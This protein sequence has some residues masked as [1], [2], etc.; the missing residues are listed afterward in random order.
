[1][2]GQPQARP[3]PLAGLDWL[4]ECDLT[5]N[6]FPC[7]RPATHT[8]HIHQCKKEEKHL[9]QDTFLVCAYTVKNCLEDIYPFR[10]RACNHAFGSF[11]D[12][13]WDIAELPKG[14]FH[15]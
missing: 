9:E 7:H 12:R 11:L 15:E 5:H 8:A 6:G 10:C 13:I 14:P 4:L 2:T 3:D 1:M